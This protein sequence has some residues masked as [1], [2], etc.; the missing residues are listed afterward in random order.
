MCSYVDGCAIHPQ[1]FEAGDRVRLSARFA[2]Q[3]SR[4]TVICTQPA[5]S[6]EDGRLIGQ[7][8]DVRWDDSG[9]VVDAV[10]SVDLEHISVVERIGDLGGEG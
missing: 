6:I 1:R 8:V 4:G 3:S 10:P 5:Y 2:D 9:C 7:H